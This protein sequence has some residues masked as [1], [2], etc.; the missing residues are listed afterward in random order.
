[1]Y[2]EENSSLNLYLLYAS[3]KDLDAR[4]N[5]EVDLTLTTVK[6]TSD[7]FVLHDQQLVKLNGNLDRE[8][9]DNYELMLTACDRGKIKMCV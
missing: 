3:V 7:M 8:S 5:G 1:M 4:L 6:G 9:V 2:I